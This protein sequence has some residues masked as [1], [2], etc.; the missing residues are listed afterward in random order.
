MTTITTL[1]SHN[2]PLPTAMQ[3][4]VIHP[5][6]D[7]DNA[8]NNSSSNNPLDN[9]TLIT[10]HPLPEI[11]NENYALIQ[12]LRAGICNTDLEILQGY[13]GFEGILV[14]YI[15]YM[16]LLLLLCCYCCCVLFC[17]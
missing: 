12:I 8:N 9:G 15:N 10:N 4:F 16:R 11:P 5:K 6:N 17:P 13:M 3:A 1:S 14:S 2:P 7:T